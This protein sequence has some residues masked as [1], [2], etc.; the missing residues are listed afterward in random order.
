METRIRKIGNSKGILIP[1]AI[2]KQCEIS[3]KVCVA[4]VDRCILIKPIDEPRKGWAEAFQKMV[5]ANDDVL[6]IP[7]VFDDEKFDDTT[8]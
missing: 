3:E 1:D 7:D 6:L 5:A 8:W 4:V 2:L